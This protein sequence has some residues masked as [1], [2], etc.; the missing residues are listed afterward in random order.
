MPAMYLWRRLKD[1]G[2]R[3]FRAWLAILIC[4]FPATLATFLG[5]SLISM[6][7][8]GGGRAHGQ[9]WLSAILVLLVFCGGFTIPVAIGSSVLAL[10]F[11]LAQRFIVG[12][13]APWL[14]PGYLAVI[15]YGPALLLLAGWET[16]EG[17][18]AAYYEGIALIATLLYLPLGRRMRLLP[19]EA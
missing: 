6:A 2:P 17:R 14:R 18:I 5:G 8:Y 12:P 15:A 4:L 1:H 3:L 9:S 7:L 11:L 19:R 10:P 13:R 16:G